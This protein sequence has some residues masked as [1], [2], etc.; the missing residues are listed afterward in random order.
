MGTKKGKLKNKEPIKNVLV[1]GG[2]GFLG[3]AIV[4]LLVER[5]CCVRSFSRSYYPELA[6]MGVDQFQGDI[7][8]KTSVEKACKGIDLVFHVAAK[9]GVWGKYS[10]Y[11]RTN[12]KGTQN[13]IET[14]KKN[15]V[16]KLIYTSSPSVIFDG[17]D[18]EGVNESFPY[19]GKY[20]AHY[21][22]TKALAEQA[23]RAASDNLL[24]V[25]LRPHL[26]WGPRDSHIVPRII[27]RAKHLAIVG[28]GKNVVDTVYIDNAAYAHILAAEKLDENPGISGNIYFISQGKPV[29]LWEMINNILKAGGLPPVKR[30][31]SHKAAWFIGAI[32]ELVYNII[33]IRSEPIMTRFVANE[34]AKSHWFDISAAQNDLGYIPGVST[35]DGLKRLESW[36][37]NRS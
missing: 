4:K 9:T 28:N 2:G 30:S 10:D 1:T 26:I 27:S 6:S 5:G 31:I 3:G 17:T 32:L 15:N 24:T 29:L 22:K 8:D 35:E 33:N 7:A 18:L 37:K 12:V 36:L 20:N 21:P 19:P 16:S 25:I 23:V 14:C 11:Y 34:L 13:I